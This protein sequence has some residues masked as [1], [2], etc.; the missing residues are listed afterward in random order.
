MN[1]NKYVNLGAN[2]GRITGDLTI[3][4]WVRVWQNP[5]GN[6]DGRQNPI[7][8]RYWS[9]WAITIE[10]DRSIT[11][12]GGQNNGPYDWA[13]APPGSFEWG[14]WVHFA[15]IRDVMDFKY[16]TY[17]NGLVV[18]VRD[19]KRYTSYGNSGAPMCVVSCRIVSYAA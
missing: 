9:E 18:D 8:K 17:I 14:E 3:A 15:F 5:N 16:H 4:F 6:G 13:H 2:P 19:T 12:Y 10:P 7:D 1:A 11:Y